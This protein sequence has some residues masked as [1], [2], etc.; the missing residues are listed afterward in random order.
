MLSNKTFLVQLH[1]MNFNNTWMEVF[2]LIF[3]IGYILTYSM[4]IHYIKSL[5]EKL[6]F[7]IQ[8]NTKLL[9]GMHEGLLILEKQD[10]CEDEDQHVMFCNKHAKKLLTT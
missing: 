3:F 6:S 7:T 2:Y 5:Y 1:P 10:D 8:E 9:N 4:V